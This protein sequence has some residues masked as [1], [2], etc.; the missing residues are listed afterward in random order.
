M[1][2]ENRIWYR[3]SDG[4]VFGYG[5]A[6]WEDNSE[7]D[8]STQ[9]LAACPGDLPDGPLTTYIDDVKVFLWTYNPETGTVTNG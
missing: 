6:S 8:A 4:A 7:W 1:L 3:V 9:A 5:Y 2:T